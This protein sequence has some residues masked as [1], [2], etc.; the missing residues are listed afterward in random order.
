VKPTSTDPRIQEAS[1]LLR[2]RRWAEARLILEPLALEGRADVE[3]RCMLGLAF[4]GLGA[5]VDAISAYSSAVARDRL[6]FDAYYSL[7]LIFYNL[8]QF[9]KACAFHRLAFDCPLPAEVQPFDNAAL[10]FA[11]MGDV[12]GVEWIMAKARAVDPSFPR[13][14]SYT[15][16]LAISNRPSLLRRLFG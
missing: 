2:E 7:G 5:T 6:C 3:R 9:E 4:R 16:G 12:A 10:A 13:K 11:S 14:F 15:Y 1:A 8:N